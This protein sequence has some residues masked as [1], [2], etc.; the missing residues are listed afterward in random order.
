[1]NTLSSTSF[2]YG[3]RV[4]SN[5]KLASCI[6]YPIPPI[7]KGSLTPGPNNVN[8]LAQ[9]S[10]TLHDCERSEQHEGERPGQM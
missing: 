8:A 7:R 5:P 2:K 1:M 9:D 10:D 4:S 6:L 3:L